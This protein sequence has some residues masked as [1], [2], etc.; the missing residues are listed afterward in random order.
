MQFGNLVFVHIHSAS[1]YPLGVEKGDPTGSIGALSRGLLRGL[2]TGSPCGDTRR[3][4]QMSKQA[5][6]W[7][8]KAAEC[9]RMALLTTDPVIRSTYLD[10]AHQRR[11]MAE[12]PMRRMR[13]TLPLRANDD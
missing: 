1:F 2:G 11:K 10:L 8:Q 13:S 4:Y 7:T 3:L 5:E 12:Q 6:L 9:E